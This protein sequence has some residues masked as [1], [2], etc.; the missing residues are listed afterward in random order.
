MKKRKT[1]KTSRKKRENH[2][3]SKIKLLLNKL[4]MLNT[5]RVL[6][7]LGIWTLSVI[8]H[9]II[10]SIFEIDEKIF[11]ITSGIVLPFYLLISILFFTRSHK[12]R[13]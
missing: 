7:I 5:K 1:K 10:N 13:E 3:S 6:I 12:N 9:Y 4:F 11:F 2:K 8:S